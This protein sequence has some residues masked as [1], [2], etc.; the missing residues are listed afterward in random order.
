MFSA[1]CGGVDLGVPGSRT[2][3]GIGAADSETPQ[4]EIALTLCLVRPCSIAAKKVGILLV[5][6]TRM[7]AVG[8]M[9]AGGVVTPGTVAGKLTKTLFPRFP[10][11]ALACVS[12]LLKP[13]RFAYW[14]GA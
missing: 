11:L 4:M 3:I 12:E 1:A 8:A 5:T 7:N 9:V 13:F 14:Q 6:V 10:A 2:R